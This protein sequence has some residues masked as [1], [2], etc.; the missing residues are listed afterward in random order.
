MAADPTA[1]AGGA[2]PSCIRLTKTGRQARRAS[3]LKSIPRARDRLAA[4]FFDTVGAGDD[5]PRPLSARARVASSYLPKGPSPEENDSCVKHPP[6]PTPCEEVV[7]S[8]QESWLEGAADEHDRHVLENLLLPPTYPHT[9]THREVRS[10]RKTGPRA[11]P[12]A[13]PGAGPQR[14][15]CAAMGGRR[16]PGRV[17]RARPSS[18]RRSSPPATRRTIDR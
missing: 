11:R 1:I 6:T 3:E 14:A 9:H 4:R 10:A 15:P 8:A 16:S 5:A 12:R 7:R 2:P 13:E 18:Q 17:W